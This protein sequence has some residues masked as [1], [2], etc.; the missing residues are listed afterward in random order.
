MAP[1]ATRADRADEVNSHAACRHAK[2]KLL[3]HSQVLECGMWAL[4]L[5]LLVRLG[6][7]L[8]E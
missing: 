7:A 1:R 5:S 3:H 4:L 6:C 2:T 8:T